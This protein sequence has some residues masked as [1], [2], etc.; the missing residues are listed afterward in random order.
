MAVRRR[1]PPYPGPVSLVLAGVRR[2]RWAPARSTAGARLAR[3]PGR[4]LD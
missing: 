1:A 3:G 4:V 2:Q